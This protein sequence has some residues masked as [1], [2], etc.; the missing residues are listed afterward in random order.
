MSVRCWL[1]IGCWLMLSAGASARSAKKPKAAPAPA[2]V[3]ADDF[4]PKL[5]EAHRDKLHPVVDDPQRYRA[6]ILITE[7]E[8][9]RGRRAPKVVRHGYR[10][11]AE[12]FYPASAIKTLAAVATLKALRGE[13]ALRRKKITVDTPLVIH[14]LFVDQKAEESEDESHL[15]GGRITLGHEIRKM[16]IVSDNQAFDRL[17]GFVGRDGLNALAQASGLEKTRVYHRLSRRR[18]PDENRWAE[19]MDFYPSGDLT[20]PPAVQRAIRVSP[21]DLAPLPAALPGVEVGRAH[22]EGDAQIPG[23]MSF[24]EKNRMGLVD[25][26]NMLIKIMRPEIPLPGAGFRLHRKDRALLRQAMRERPGESTDPLLPEETYDPLR[27]KPILGGLTRLRP[28]EDWRVWNKAGKAYGFRIE[29][30]YVEHPTLKGRKAIFF[31]VALY[32]NENGV[33]N[34]NLYEYDA[35]ADPF[36][37]DLAEAA[38]LA[39]WGPK[40]KARSHR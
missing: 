34:D 26:Q 36:I 18:T 9:V 8:R 32:V 10:V 25:L 15:D 1:W 16:S 19:P 37:H 29:N 33:V 11:D 35:V 39:L 31:T 12:Y 13:R 22:V 4:I 28:I 21:D 38:V 14:R 7:V 40:V 6:Q 27:F 20:G 3:L 30:A 5:F 23:P 17:Y 24:R 2:P